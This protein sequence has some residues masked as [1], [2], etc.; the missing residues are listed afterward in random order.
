MYIPGED[1]MLRPKIEIIISILI[2][3]ITP[4]SEQRE[5]SLSSLSDTAS[6][7]CTC[8]IKQSPQAEYGLYNR[9]EHQQ[10]VQ[11]STRSQSALRRGPEMGLVS[12]SAILDS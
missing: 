10:F 12:M 9:L 11:K 3:L 6:Q 2:K 4:D 5:G 8:T 1:R 7:V